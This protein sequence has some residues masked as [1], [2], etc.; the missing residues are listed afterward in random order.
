MVGAVAVRQRQGPQQLT[1]TVGPPALDRIALGEQVANR[2]AAAN[3]YGP[4]PQQS[5][6][7]HIAVALEAGT[8]EIRILKEGKGLEHSAQRWRARQGPE[9]G[10]IEGH[11]RQL[12]ERQECRI[13][14]GTA[15]HRHAAA[16]NRKAMERLTRASPA[17]PVAARS[18]KDWATESSR[19][20][21]V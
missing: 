20:T 19:T 8:G 11:Q 15:P 14:G 17:R 10:G 21:K 9:V 4:L 12:E 16:Q 1:H 13:T 6:F 7:D 5:G 3:E 18:E 2:L